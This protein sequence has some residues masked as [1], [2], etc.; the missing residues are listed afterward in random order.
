[1]QSRLSYLI[2]FF[3]RSS[4]SNLRIAKKSNLS[5]SAS[6]SLLAKSL[7][8]SLSL[9]K[10]SYFFSEDLLLEI[11]SRGF[12]ISDSA[13][14]SYIKLTK[15]TGSGK[16]VIALNTKPSY[17][18]KS[19]QTDPEAEA[20]EG[21]DTENK[22]T[23]ITRIVDLDATVFNQ[24]LNQAVAFN[25]SLVETELII[26]NITFIEQISVDAISYGFNLFEEYKGPLFICFNDDVKAIIDD[27]L[28]SHGIDQDMKLI[29]DLLSVDK[30]L[31]LRLA[32]MNNIIKFLS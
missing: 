3:S 25:C 14:S 2:R 9:E 30:Q 29:I 12:T 6:T 26:Y 19:L 4:N 15:K 31:R 21:S 1:M 18:N 13:N 24:K 7:K 22:D 10:E 17:I 11:K 28:I 32:W 27:Y 16:F 8:E 5:Y 23:S 20:E